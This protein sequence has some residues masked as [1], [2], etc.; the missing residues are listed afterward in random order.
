[1]SFEFSIRKYRQKEIHASEEKVAVTTPTRGITQQL[2][3]HTLPEA[4]HI[5]SRVCAQHSITH[6]LGLLHA[7]E[8]AQKNFTKK[9]DKLLRRL[10]LLGEYILSHSKHLYYDVTPLLLGCDT[11]LPKLALNRSH[12]R[13]GTNLIDYGENIKKT[14]GGS[15]THPLTC[16]IC[17]FTK[18]PSAHQ[19]QDLWIQSNLVLED[20]IKTS[21]QILEYT[22]PAIKTLATDVAVED[23]LNYPHYEGAAQADELILPEM[24]EAKLDY[25]AVPESNA[26]QI[27]LRKKPVKAGPQARLNR[28]SHRLNPTALKEKPEK[29]PKENPYYNICAQALELIHYV[30]ETQMILDQLKGLKPNP[31]PG[32]PHTRKKVTGHSLLESPHGLHLQKVVLEKQKIVEAKI[33]TADQINIA[34]FTQDVETLAAYKKTLTLH[35]KKEYLRL[36][37]SAY[38]LCPHCLTT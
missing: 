1:M 29:L 17:G 10:L 15:T 4:I 8:D 14:V 22:L 2:E 38:D 33:I 23:G 6:T 9:Q 3:G 31:N 36:L 28:F 16:T 18:I 5:I 19:I 24:Y 34:S 13:H 27:L 21:D 30:E 25:Y 11:H 20:A 35:Q 37:Q 32:L 7:I 26:D 12:L